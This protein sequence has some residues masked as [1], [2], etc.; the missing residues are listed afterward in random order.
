MSGFSFWFQFWFCVG[1]LLDYFH[2]TVL[3]MHDHLAQNFI[4]GYVLCSSYLKRSNY[5]LILLHNCLV[6]LLYIY[7]LL[8]CLNR[9]KCLSIRKWKFFKGD[10][11]RYHL[12]FF[13]KMI[14]SFANISCPQTFK[15]LLQKS[16]LTIF[17]TLYV[18]GDGIQSL[19][20]I[21]HL[22]ALSFRHKSI[23]KRIFNTLFK[24]SIMFAIWYSLIFDSNLGFGNK[25]VNSTVR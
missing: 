25:I 7:T 17:V 9:S 6:L 21:R 24:K 18:Y 20:T 4:S 23:L 10:V 19:N 14:K 12:F 3:F 1:L 2:L 13:W 15:I 11:V 8:V 16:F 5:C 22:T